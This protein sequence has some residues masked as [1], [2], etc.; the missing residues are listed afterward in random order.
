MWG[1]SPSLVDCGTSA[2]HLGDPSFRPRE[3]PQ[4]REVRRFSSAACGRCFAPVIVGVGAA[5]SPS[6]CRVPRCGIG[7]AFNLPRADSGSCWCVCVP[8]TS[9]A[10]SM[11]L[12]WVWCSASA[13]PPPCFGRYCTARA[14][15]DRLNHPG[16]P[17]H[18]PW[19]RRR[20]PAGRS[21]L[22]R[23]RR[24]RSGRDLLH[25]ANS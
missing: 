19:V 10:L 15:A 22:F 24:R 16:V 25:F 8:G 7:S 20:H 14:H 6:S 12:C 18:R 9:L 23:R 2:V 17:L 3:I 5:G 21:Q 4:C 13:P 11:W 1:S